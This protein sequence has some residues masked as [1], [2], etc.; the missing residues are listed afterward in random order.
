MPELV[1]IYLLTRART[2]PG[3]TAGVVAAAPDEGT[4]RALASSVYGREGSH[5]WFDPDQSACTILGAPAA[6]DRKPGVILSDR[7]EDRG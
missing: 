4:A 3:E 7:P 2:G 5:A 1:K 6:A